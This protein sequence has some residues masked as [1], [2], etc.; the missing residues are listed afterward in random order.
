MSTSGS[1]TDEVQDDMWL[2]YI[3]ENKGW[4]NIPQSDLSSDVSAPPSPKPSQASTHLY[5]VQDAC[6]SPGPSEASTHMYSGPDACLSSAPSDASTH[7]YSPAVKFVKVSDV[8]DD[9]LEVTVVHLADVTWADKVPGYPALFN[10]K[11]DTDE[12]VYTYKLL[13]D[14]GKGD[15]QIV[16]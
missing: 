13:E 7:M 10:V 16:V 6:P 14:Y 11:Y 4:Y 15:L 8:T 5:S 3:D 2:A 12:H 9:E 1:G